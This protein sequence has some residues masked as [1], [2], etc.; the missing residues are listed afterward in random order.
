MKRSL[1]ALLFLCIG[2]LVA[3][4][5]E[6]P[7]WEQPEVFAI[8]RLPARATLTPYTSFAEALQ[9]G[10]SQW[11]KDISGDWKFHW[12][13]TPAEAPEG[14]EAVGYDDGAWATIP[15][16]GNWEINGYGVPIYTNVNYPFP[17]NP[18]FIPHDD[19]PTGCY[20]HSF[21]LPEAWESRRVILHFE[22]GL[23][24]MEVWLNGSS[25]GYAEGTKTAVEFDITPYIV[26]GKNLLAVKGYRWSDGSYLED[27]DFWRL[28]G[29]DRGVKIYSVD[30]VRIADAFVIADLDKGYKSGL[31]DARVTLENSGKEPFSGV[32]ELFLVDAK[33]LS[34]VNQKREVAIDGGASLELT[35]TKVVDKVKQWSDEH[36][37]L[38]TTVVVLRGEDG[39]VVEATSVRTGFRKVEIRDAQ[40]LLN[41]KRLMING[42]NIHEHNPATGHVINRELMLKDIALMKQHNINAVRT[43]HYPQPTE[44]YDLCDEY[45]ILLVDE[46][47]IEAHG[48]GTGWHESYPD[49]HPSHRAEWKGAHH[50]RVRAMVERDKNHPSVILWSMG[51]ESSDGEVYGEMYKWIKERDRSRF[52]QL[53]QGYGGPHTDIV[54]P[55]YPPM[56]EFRRYAERTDMRKPYILCEFAH[57]MGNSTGNFRE[58][59]DIM[60]GHPHMQG[61]FIWDWADQG[62]DAT[63]RDGRHYWGYGGDFGAWMYPHDENFCCNGIV[64]P[65][66]TPH[67]GINEVKKVY[68]DINFEMVDDGK[69]R[70]INDFNFRDLSEYAFSYEVL[71]EGHSVASNE[72]KGVSCKAGESVI[73][74][75]ELPEKMADKEYMLNLYAKQNASHPLIPQDYVVAT[76]QIVLSNYNFDHTV[77]TGTLEIERG[78]G[79]LVAYAKEVGVLF[80]TRNGRL[81]RYVADGKDIMVQLPEPWFWRAP[82]DND[83]GAGFQRTANVWRTN[84]GRTIDSSVEEFEDRVVVRNVRELVDAPSLFTTT[85]TFMADGSLKVE[86]DWERKGEFVPELPRLGMRMIFG[87]EYKNFTYY[88]RGPWENYSD[89]KESSFV[90]LY[91]QSTD[92][93]LFPYVR[94]QES[95]NRC[96]VRW[97]ELTNGEGV[98]IRVEGLQPLSVSAMPYRSEDLDPGFTKKQMHYSDKEPRREVVLHVDLAQRGLGGDQS[99]G[100]E[101]H[102]PYRLTADNYSYGYIIRPIVK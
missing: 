83:W 75:V 50:D 95:G 53:E 68:Q 36:P 18:P 92:E 37:N 42:V 19:N 7:Y 77:P 86:V 43:S 5:E 28:S 54:C 71:C 90:G 24:A 85:Y 64:S 13:A 89:R 47:N 82:T 78:E 16:P 39:A 31:L 35:F 1:L 56:G 57:A 94:P 4:A 98:G 14:F 44:W 73:V 22:S 30:D 11:V 33:G 32:A 96:D 65:D 17:K 40:L 99:W 41:G 88:G 29:F 81:E 52:V 21:Q 15:V 45:G 72:I 87:E 6:H 63:G 2:C 70:I 100:A 12:T 10:E 67:P 80:N 51:N 69:V 58:Y 93:Q 46:A 76:E 20:R 49:F 60:E 23:A 79:W 3:S 55:M 8:N 84:R 66:R 62:I 59:F 25:V 91:E 34:I 97:L 26:S 38:Y 48:C 74:G 61:G 27:Q 101:P 9:R 102:D